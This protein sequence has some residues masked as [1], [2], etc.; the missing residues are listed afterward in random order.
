[1]TIREHFKRVFDRIKYGCVALAIVLVAL[2]EWRY[3]HLTRLQNAGIG[4]LLGVPISAILVLV[5]RGRFL[6][7]RCGTDL[8][9]LRNREVRK[10][11]RVRGR[12]SADRRLLWDVWNACP[13][14]G[15]SFDEP[16]R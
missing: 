2:T 13:H 4:L 12:F 8:G 7:P 5:L 16:Y 14:C 15:V 9:K 10:K 1:M 6:C 3:P 11:R